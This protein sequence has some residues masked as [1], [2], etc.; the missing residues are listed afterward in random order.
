VRVLSLAV[1]LLL[2]PSFVVSAS[3]TARRFGA[4]AWRSTSPTAAV[5]SAR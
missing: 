4:V 3:L 5:E 2:A 1:K